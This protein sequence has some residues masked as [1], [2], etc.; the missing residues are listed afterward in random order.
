MSLLSPMG[1]CGQPAGETA[2]C[3]PQPL[4]GRAYHG[5]RGGSMWDYRGRGQKT[6]YESPEN[7]QKPGER[8]QAA[9]V[10]AGG[11]AGLFL[12]PL[13][14]RCGAFQPDMD[15]QHRAGGAGAIMI[16]G[17]LLTR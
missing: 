10:H 7:A 13:G 8:Q 16:Q 14:Q 9:L 4:P 15:K 2:G 3:N 1:V 5:P 12:C 6:A 17:N 11:G